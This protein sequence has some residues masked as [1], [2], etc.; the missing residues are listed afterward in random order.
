MWAVGLFLQKRK[1]ECKRPQSLPNKLTQ[2][3]SFLRRIIFKE[4]T[5]EMTTKDNDTELYKCILHSQIP[6]HT[7]WKCP[8]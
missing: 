5:Q 3:Y 8:W 7:P 1:V 2:C 4:G 6:K